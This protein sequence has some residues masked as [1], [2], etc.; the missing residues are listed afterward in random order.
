MVSTKIVRN[1]TKISNVSV[2]LE[3]KPFVFPVIIQFMG[4][5]ISYLAKKYFLPV[6]TDCFQGYLPRYAL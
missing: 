2:D 6:I 1:M 5:D 4:P 3:L